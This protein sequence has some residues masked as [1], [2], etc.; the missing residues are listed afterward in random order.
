MFDSHEN[1]FD[2][3]EN[4]TQIVT[5]KYRGL[6]INYAGMGVDMKIDMGLEVFVSRVKIKSSK[7][8]PVYY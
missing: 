5:M 4:A 3:N 7:S 1:L 6:S 8:V 2:C